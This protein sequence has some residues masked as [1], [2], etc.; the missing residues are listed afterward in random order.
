VTSRIYIT[1]TVR[2]I[3]ETTYKIYLELLIAEESY[4]NLYILILVVYISE[5]DIQLHIV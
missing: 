1:L 2:L 4:P 5:G 3:P